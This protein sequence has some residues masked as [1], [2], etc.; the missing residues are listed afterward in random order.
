MKIADI[1]RLIEAIKEEVAG[2]RTP[3]V[4]LIAV[5]TRDPF[6]VLV[7]TILSARTKD[8]TTAAAA[9]RLFRHAQDP[10]ALAELPEEEIRKLIYPVGFYKNKAGYL[11]RLPAA[12]A[13]WGGAVPS[14]LESLMRLPGV[15]RKTANLVLSVAF[16]R[17]AICVDTHVHRI[18]NIWGYVRTRTPLETEMA[19]REKLPVTYWR[20]IN[21]LLVAFGQGTCTPVAPHCDACVIAAD[22]P[23]IGVTPRKVGPP[24]APRAG[25]RTGKT[26]ISWNVNGIRAVE[27][28]GFVDTVLALAPDIF[29]IQETKAHPEQLSEAL[30]TIDG[31]TAYWHSAARKGYSGVGVY[32]KTAPLQVTYGLGL[33]HFDDEGRVMTLEFSDFFLINAYFPNAQ[34]GLLRL[35]YKL[36][37]NRAL[38]RMAASLAARK[39]TIICGD[40]NVAHKA[41]DL[42]NPKSNEQNPGYSP[43]E[44]AWMDEFIG[45]GFVDTFRIFDDGPDNYTWWTYRFN[46]RERNIG[47]RIDYFCVDSASEARVLGAAILK[48]IMG[49]DH[50]P[51]SLEFK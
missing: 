31:Y 48:D 34:H 27:K 11:A 4:D 33:D 44:R 39:S 40:F 49:S 19:L 21:S 37:F 20:Q 9:A 45:S 46:A 35:G 15:G 6:K 17:D 43:E 8:E 14:D 23:K 42:K 7:A 41:I 38:H 32:T 1:S 36:D 28:R 50:C 3:V 18:M 24:T 10:A 13:A 51:V 5:Q 47:W 29:A 25:K 30:R 22:C 16:G 12:L 26:L 2:Y